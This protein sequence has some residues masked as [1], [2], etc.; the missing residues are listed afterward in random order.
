MTGKIFWFSVFSVFYTY[1]GYPFLVW[2]FAS[3]RPKPDPYPSYTP[4]TT[5][6]IAAYNEEDVIEDKIRNCL[7]LDY[8]TNQ[9]EVLVVTDGSDDRTPEI[10]QSFSKENVICMHNPKRQGKMAAINRAMPFAQ[11]EVIVFSDANNIFNPNTIKELVS[12]LQKS[13]IGAVSGAK[14]ILQGDGSLGK[15]EGLYWKY[16]SFIKKQ[17]SR[18]G[19]CTGVAGEILA[20]RKNC[21]VAPPNGIINDDFYIAMEIIRQGY[22]IAYMPA[23]ISYERVSKTA[24]DEIRRRQR[25]IA[26]RFQAI[27][28]A[29]FILPFNR[30]VIVW[31]IISHKFLRPLIP[32]AMIAAAIS[33]LIAVII[34]SKEQDTKGKLRRLENPYSIQLLALQI[35]FYGVA[36]LGSFLAIEKKGG[37][38]SKLLYLP[39][40]LV[41][42]NIA[43]LKGFSQYLRK[44]QSNLWERIPRR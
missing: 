15:S 40:F 35:V 30:P 28:M 43:A 19:C 34:P 5:L 25:I 29:K 42:S 24:Q 3:L 37:K 39:T 32:F 22:D 1:F 13:H 38:L 16:K 36:G 44:R 11:G 7:E 4:K 10:V 6:L 2:L 27:G 17:E 23:A 33:N 20:V 8:P 31:Q 21:Y 14:T 18:L 9:I 26:G 41:N 12:P